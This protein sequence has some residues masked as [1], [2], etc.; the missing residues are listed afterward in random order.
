VDHIVELM[1]RGEWEGTRTTLALAAEWGISRGAVSDYAREASGIIR[2]LIEGD[3]ADIKAE[4]LAGI[5]RVRLIALELVKTERVGKDEYAQVRAPNVSAALQ[6]YELKAKLLGL[7]PKG[8]IDLNVK[9]TEDDLG[10]LSEEELDTLLRAA[11][12]A[13]GD[14]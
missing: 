13:K 6:A 8:E 14:K 3:P 11:R 7:F 12:K 5:E 1:A 9:Q 10:D 2:R 4:I